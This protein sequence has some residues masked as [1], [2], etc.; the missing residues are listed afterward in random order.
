[1]PARVE[2]ADQV[3]EAR[4]GGLQVRRQLGDLVAE[5][6]QF[7][8]ALRGNGDDGRV[9]VHGVLPWNDSTPGFRGRRGRVQDGVV[10]PS[11]GF[12]C[13]R[14]PRPITGPVRAAGRASG[15]R[16]RSAPRPLGRSCQVENAVHGKAGR[17]SRSGRLNTRRRYLKNRLGIQVT[18]QGTRTMRIRTAVI[19][20]TNGQTTTLGTGTREIALAM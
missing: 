20:P 18:V 17:A 11:H 10:R 3:Q 13:R 2:V 5:L 8:D 15:A 16:R 4:A 6:L 7:R 19:A 14:A 1:A 9:D 12:R